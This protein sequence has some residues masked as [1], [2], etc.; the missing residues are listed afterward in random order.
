MEVDTNKQSVFFLYDPLILVTKYRRQ[1]IDEEISDYAKST[2][3][4]I[5]EPYPITFV[6]WNQDKNN[7]HI[8][9]NAQPKTALTTCINAYKSVSL[10]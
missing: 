5:A 7:I 9:F 1:V 10:E 8:L 6:E 2:F 4:R 3:E